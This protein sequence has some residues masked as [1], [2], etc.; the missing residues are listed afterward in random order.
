MH[1]K[2][3]H[4]SV[5]GFSFDNSARENKLI[6]AGCCTSLVHLSFRSSQSGPHQSARQ[7]LFQFIF[8]NSSGREFSIRRRN[9]QYCL[10]SSRCCLPSSQNKASSF[11][12]IVLRSDTSELTLRRQ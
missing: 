4:F 7:F 3:Q 12:T 1:G 10:V 2:E 5:L 6:K 8:W 11:H 9:D